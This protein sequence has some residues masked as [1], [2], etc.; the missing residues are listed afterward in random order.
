ML[1][2]HRNERSP[3]P[4]NQANQDRKAGFRHLNQIQREFQHQCVEP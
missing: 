2:F 1:A 3:L 4:K